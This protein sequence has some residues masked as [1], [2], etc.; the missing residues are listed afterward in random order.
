MRKDYELRLTDLTVQN[1]KAQKDL[2]TVIAQREKEIE[3]HTSKA[4]LTHISHNQL[5]QT[6][7]LD[8]KQV[9]AEKRHLETQILN[10]NKE[11]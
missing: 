4:S 10:K 9:M 7:N 5:L 8:M 3:G 1:D 11:I 2:K 6:R